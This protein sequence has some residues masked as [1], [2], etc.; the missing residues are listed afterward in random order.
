M[1]DI[2]DSLVQNIEQ[3]AF[4]YFYAQSKYRR[5]QQEVLQQEQWLD[6]HL[7]DEA[8]AHLQKLQDADLCLDT[9]EREAIIRIALAVGI[10]CALPG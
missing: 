7:D 6:E 1:D 5:S 4:P 2:F 10:R 9:L 3:G 8:K